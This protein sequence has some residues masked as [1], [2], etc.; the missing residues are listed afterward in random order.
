MVDFKDNNHTK[1][2]IDLIDIIILLWNRKIIIFTL[3]LLVAIIAGII[4]KLV[5]KPV[6]DTKLNVVIS[7]SEKYDTRYG[8]YILPISTN[9]QII[10]LITSNEVLIKTIKDMNYSTNEM[11]VDSLRRRINIVKSTSNSSANQNSFEVI[12]SADNPEKSLLLAEALYMNYFEFMDVMI[13]KRAISHYM[14]KFYVE[15]KAL[16]YSLKNTKEILVK[17][18]EL[19]IN[20]PKLIIGAEANLELQTQ[21]TDNSNYIVP[22]K[23]INPNYLQIENDIIKSKQ[24]IN[25]FESS[26]DMNNQFLQELEN[27]M[28]L[29]EKYEDTGIYDGLKGSSFVGIVETSIY[30]PSTPVAPI[31]RTSPNNKLNIFI[32]AVIGGMLGVIAVLFKEYIFIKGRR[33]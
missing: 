9:E 23:T 2:E 24:T 29:V 3:T 16:E 4:S 25:A 6:Y 19:L 17:N 33:E 31:Y 28:K 21:L 7:I 1:N 18:E 12:V 5:I 10:E 30:L 15:N 8:E 20:T 22:T 32:G 26:I 11:S 14:N 13:K 27:E